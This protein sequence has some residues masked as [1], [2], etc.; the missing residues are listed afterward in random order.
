MNHSVWDSG[1]RRCGSVHPALQMVDRMFAWVTTLHQVAALALF[2]DD[3]RGNQVLSN[4]RTRYGPTAVTTLNAAKA[5]PHTAYNGNLP[6][7]VEDTAR[8]ADQLRP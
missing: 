6:G 5:G 2:D 1:G 7:F 3:S 8:L 4:L